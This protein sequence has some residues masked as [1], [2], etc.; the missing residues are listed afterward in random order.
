M[1]KVMTDTP[2][3]TMTISS[4]LL[5]MYFTIFMIQKPHIVG[6]RNPNLRQRD[7]LTARGDSFRIS[8]CKRGSK[9]FLAAS[10]LWK[11][12]LPVR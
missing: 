5:R 4:I 1:P 2:A 7:A 9:P 3:S 8:G 11:S 12:L 10:L 6:L